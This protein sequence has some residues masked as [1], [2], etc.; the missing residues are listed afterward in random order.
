MVRV[1]PPLPIDAHLDR[2]VGEVRRARA[3]V[4]VAAPG[5]GKTT[6]VPPALAGDGPVLVLQPRRIAA[7]N[8]ARR[9]ADE[10]AWTLGEEVGWHVRFERRFSPRTR[11]LL[12]T[13][14][15]LTARLQ[16]DPL[17]SDFRTIVLDEFHERSLHADLGLALARQAWLARDELRLV[18]MSATLDPEPIRAYLGGCPS[19]DI[20]GHAHPLSLDYAPRQTL[21]EAVCELAATSRGRV[22]C[23]LPGAPEIRRAQEEIARRAPGLEVAPLHG[24]LAPEE[25]D[26]AIAIAAVAGGGPRVILAT[27]IAETSLTVPGVDTVIDTGLHKVAR[28]DPAR[29]IDSLDTERISLDSADQRAGRAAR[30]G[31]G[32]VRRLWDARD[33]LRPHRE[34]DIARVDLA[35]PLLDVVAWGG[36]AERFAWFEAPPIASLQAAARLLERLGALEHGR[37]TP[38]GRLVHALPIHPRLA[39]ILIAAHGAHEAAA[40]CAALAER[41]VLPPRHEATT[42]DL[43]AV[44]DGWRDAPGHLRQVARLLEDAVARTPGVAKRAHVDERELRQAIFLGYP[45]RLALRRPGQRLPGLGREPRSER[46]LLASGTGATLGTESGVHDGD[47]LVALDVQA[48]TVS[49][50]GGSVGTG[51]A[52]SGPAGAVRVPAPDA[53]VRIA[54]RVEPEW[55]SPTATERVHLLDPA[56]GRVRAVR[57]LRY[58]AIVMAERPDEVDADEQARLLADAYRRRGWSDA[59]RRLFARLRFA[60]LPADDMALVDAASRRARSLDAIDLSG[61]ID[62]RTRADLDRL[63]PET[64]AVPSGRRV[65]LR[66]EDEAPGDGESGTSVSAAVKLQELFGLAE[67]PRVGARREPVLLHLL[68]PNGRPV[69]MT[70]DLRSFWTRTYPEVRRELRGRYPKHPWPEDPW[71][72]VPTARTLKRK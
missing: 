65:P 35:A 32:R 40:I 22:L 43:L 54:S 53:R 67:T 52:E 20:A 26:R 38:L 27:N 72:A 30:L 56:T 2:I 47:W 51:S 69:Q 25:Q 13:E 10:Q 5:A 37:L 61:S 58:D 23:F 50:G 31:P 55:V 8:L 36:D 17:A 4:I 34:P 44:V 3:A 16:Q 9:I 15:I 63:A 70:R 48:V 7:R 6:R 42:C 57:R 64:L 18:V 11:V 46:M 68:A 12:A 14:G 62:A 29:G 33:R 39:R 41:H 24:S 19:I 60:G 28:Y 49:V 21:S 71:T 45:D 66:Y 1:P 59:D